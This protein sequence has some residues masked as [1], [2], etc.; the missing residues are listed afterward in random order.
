MRAL[1]AWSVALAGD[2]PVPG[3]RLLRRFFFATGEVGTVSTRRRCPPGR[4][5]TDHALMSDIAGCQD[6]AA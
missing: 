1:A 5:T 6:G 3:L 4:A 2:L